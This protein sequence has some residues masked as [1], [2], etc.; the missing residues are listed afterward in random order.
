M[1]QNDFNIANQPFWNARADLNNA[2][3]AIAGNS[4]GATAPTATFAN[5]WW[6]DTTAGVMK[7]RNNADTAW[8]VFEP[9]GGITRSAS[10]PAID[11]NPAGGV[12]TVWLRIT[13]GEM[14]C[15]TDATAGAN[16]WV[17]I[18]D[19]T[20]GIPPI[21]T[22]ATGGVITN[23]GGYT[24]H[25]FSSSGVFEVTSLGSNDTVEYLIIAGGGSGASGFYSGG[26]GSGGYL[27]STLSVAVQSYSITVGGGGAIN[28]TYH[29][30][31]N[32]GFNSVFSSVTS[33]GGGYGS[34]F[35][36]V[37]AGG[38]GGSAGGGAGRSD[39]S[40][41]GG[42]ATSSPSQGNDGGSTPSGANSRG[43]G[44]GGS[45]AVGV[46]VTGSLASSVGGTGGVGLASSIT[47]SE[48]YRAAGGG[49]GSYFDSSV[50]SLGG[51]GGGGSGTGHSSSGPSATAATIN[52]GSG[53][54]GGNGETVSNGFSTAG[55]SG[56]VIIR[57]Q[58]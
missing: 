17:N 4:T 18:G 49:G 20:G 58:S 46:S 16:I 6:Y 56:I 33:T 40:G 53:G 38:N 19:G 11:T 48:I 22:V 36:S 37:N 44:G 45:G 52:T 9:G 29:A 13:T 10:D 14:Y 3:A 32:A 41:T 15:C 35:T 24:I 8:E 25:T 54:G 42:T 5:M 50:V 43:A 57:Y 2:F 55:A 31:G 23:S 39:A 34:G 7:K 51:N 27:T 28:T 30:N 21:S 47:G 12:G 1:A 26:G